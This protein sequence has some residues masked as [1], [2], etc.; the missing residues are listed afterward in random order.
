MK[1]ISWLTLVVY[2]AIQKLSTVSSSTPSKPFIMPPKK[3]RGTTDVDLYADRFHHIIQ[4]WMQGNSFVKNAFTMEGIFDYSALVRCLEN[5]D[6][7]NAL[8]NRNPDDP[9]RDLEISVEIAERLR[10]CLSYI[11]HLQM[12]FGSVSEDGLVDISEKSYYAFDVFY[13]SRTPFVTYRDDLASEAKQKRELIAA[14]IQAAHDAAAA[15]AVTAAAAQAQLDAL[16]LSATSSGTSSGTAPVTSPGTGNA[17]PGSNPGA[18]QPSANPAHL[19][20]AT[21]QRGVKLDQ[22]NFPQLKTDAGWF[23]F[24]RKFDMHC[25]LHGFANVLDESFV[26]ADAPAQAL[27]DYQNKYLMVVMTSCIQTVKGKEIV[28]KHSDTKDAQKA[29]IELNEHYTGAA[30]IKR[31]SR[32]AVLLAKLQTP[33]APDLRGVSLSAAIGE[34]EAWL[35]EHDALKGVTT[36]GD[37][38]LEQ[39]N[40]FIVNVKPLGSIQTMQSLVAALIPAGSA[41]PVSPDATILLYKQQAEI[42]DEQLKKASLTKRS[43]I[44]NELHR[45]REIRNL[46]MHRGYPFSQVQCESVLD[47]NLDSDQWYEV[48]MSAQRG[49]EPGG[50]RATMPVRAWKSLTPQEQQLWDQLSNESKNIILNSRL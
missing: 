1:L 15:S 32:A 36:S 41:N 47:N 42:F 24:H 19:A 16:T 43:R 18:T 48:C 27:F 17:N 31:K 10:C 34:W 5:P 4:V 29:L 46:Y 39:F 21:L 22:S 37:A 14:Q 45:V 49:P 35:T 20:L 9:D 11:N 23:D 8:K 3:T 12:K 38:K 40:Q 26:P 6:A 25:D 13:V 30:S 50:E 2:L 33:L 7:I 44:V 28:A